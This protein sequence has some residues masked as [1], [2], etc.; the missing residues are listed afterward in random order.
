MTFIIVV[1]TDARSK[2]GL[3]LISAGGILWILRATVANTVK[4][5][6][7]AWQQAIIAQPEIAEL[8]SLARIASNR[9]L[10]RFMAV[11]AGLAFVGGMMGVAFG[12]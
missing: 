4:H 10:I 11:S 3:F 8:P 2:Y 5:D 7:Q 12:V 6:E 1:A 9:V